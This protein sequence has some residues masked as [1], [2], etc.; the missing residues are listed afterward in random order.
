MNFVNLHLIKKSEHLLEKLNE[1]YEE[2]LKVDKEFSGKI[3][4]EFICPLTNKLFLQPV[5]FEDGTVFEKQ[6]IEKWMELFDVNPLNENK[7]N[8]NFLFYY[9]ISSEVNEYYESVKMFL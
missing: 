4:E 7:L 1:L 2:Y 6:A 5:K 9:N 3:P 8:K